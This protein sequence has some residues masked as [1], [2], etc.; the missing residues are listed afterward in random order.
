MVDEGSNLCKSCHSSHNN[1]LYGHNATGW[2][3]HGQTP[4]RTC[5]KKFYK[6]GLPITGAPKENLLQVALVL[7]Q[8]NYYILTGWSS[9]DDERNIPSNGD[10]AGTTPEGVNF[11]TSFMY[12]AWLLMQ[13]NYGLEPV[14]LPLRPNACSTYF[15][16]LRIVQS[17]CCSLHQK[18]YKTWQR[19][20]LGM[21]WQIQITVQGSVDQICTDICM[22]TALAI[23]DDWMALINR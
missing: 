16:V 4:S 1:I 5:T 9:R 19:G 23:L 15:L 7:Q 12:Q 10:M 20:Q 11:Y 21:D 13:G 3:Q 14:W 8:G 2:K 17:C 6:E 18:F 22:G